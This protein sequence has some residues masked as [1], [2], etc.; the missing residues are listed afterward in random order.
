MRRPA[1]T[2][3]RLAAAVVLVAAAGCG[4]D[5]GP[6]TPTTTIAPFETAAGATT[7][8]PAADAVLALLDAAPQRRFTARYAVFRPLGAVTS[9]ALVVHDLDVAVVEVADVRFVLGATAR[10]CVAGRC[11]D[12]VND[13]RVS[14]R[15][16]MGAAFFAE[17]PARALRVSVARR[18]GPVVASSATVAG[19]PATCATVPVLGGTE[20]YCASDL[21]AVAVVE[22][23]D[24][25][26]TAEDLTDTVDRTRLGP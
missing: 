19:R 22:R 16:P 21:G 1:R 12:G 26:I 17:R 20:R 10:T 4:D 15:L 6:A 23:A 25:R 18:A 3:V 9:S 7:G 24:V 13:A 2:L 14:D 5:D 11:E 8:D